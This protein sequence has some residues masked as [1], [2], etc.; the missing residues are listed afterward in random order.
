MPLLLVCLTYGTALQ[1][2]M[3]QSYFYKELVR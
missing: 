2:Q 3:E 1:Y